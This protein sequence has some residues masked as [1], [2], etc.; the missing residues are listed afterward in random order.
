MIKSHL[1]SSCLLIWCLSSVPPF[2]AMSL[3]VFL[4]PVLLWC[5]HSIVC[6][7]NIDFVV[8]S[9]LWFQFLPC[10][11]ISLHHN[12]VLMIYIYNLDFNMISA[13]WSSSCHDF[14]FIFVIHVTIWSSRLIVCIWI[15]N[16]DFNTI[17]ILCFQSLLCL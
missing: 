8:T 17:S 6:I 9:V 14:E 11:W 5:F 13:L 7:Y 16:L 4:I 2:S 15:Y 1:C 3:N 12:Y 10:L